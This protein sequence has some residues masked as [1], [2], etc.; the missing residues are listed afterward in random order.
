MPE[1]YSPYAKWHTKLHKAYKVPLE[2]A[3]KW[4]CTQEKCHTMIGQSAHED[5]GQ[6]QVGLGNQGWMHQVGMT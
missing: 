5:N 6:L 3:P 2:T 4:N 1:R